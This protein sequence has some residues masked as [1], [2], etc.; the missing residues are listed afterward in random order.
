MKQGQAK[1]DERSDSFTDIPY[2]EYRWPQKDDCLLRRS[3]SW[4]HGVQ[5][6]QHPMA[7][8]SHQW[9]GFMKAADGLIEMSKQEGFEQEKNFVIY[10]ILHN[11]R[12]G[13][14]IALKWF[15]VAYGGYSYEDI[16]KT[17]NLMSLWRKCRAIIDEHGDCDKESTEIVEQIVKEFDDCDD[18]GEAFRYGW[19]KKGNS[20]S[21]PEYKI[22]MDNLRCVMQGVRNYLDGLD[23]WLD[24]LQEPDQER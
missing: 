1:M 24:F 21:L 6:C 11:Y 9:D 2:M 22:D 4:R 7:R 10:P 5:F 23:G 12:H 16:P 3:K 14:E 13:L 15:L 19:N 17:H 8:H 20:I 18:T